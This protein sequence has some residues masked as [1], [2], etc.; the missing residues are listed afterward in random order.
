MYFSI[1]PVVYYIVV[2]LYVCY[3]RLHQLQRDIHLLR[4]YS[5]KMLIVFYNA[6]MA[7]GILGIPKVTLGFAEHPQKHTPTMDISRATRGSFIVTFQTFQV[8]PISASSSTP[9]SQYVIHRIY[10]AIVSIK[11]VVPCKIHKL[12]SSL[13]RTNAAHKDYHS[14]GSDADDVRRDNGSAKD[15]AL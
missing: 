14:Q 10:V 6:S 8:S 1:C 12:I 15:S 4:S 2:S 5:L 13:L 11:H 9:P 3:I 7:V